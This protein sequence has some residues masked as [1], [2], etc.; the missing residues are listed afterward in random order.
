MEGVFD[1]GEFNKCVTLHKKLS[2]L[3]NYPRDEFFK[4]VFAS[5]FTNN[6][7]ITHNQRRDDADVSNVN[8]SDGGNDHL[9]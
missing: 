2:R 8:L 1:R 9:N 5:A 4:A 3:G 6:G 7:A